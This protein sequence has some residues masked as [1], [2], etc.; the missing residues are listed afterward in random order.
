MSCS[1]CVSCEP[2]I[3][4]AFSHLG[5]IKWTW[6]FQKPAVSVNPAQSI[7]IRSSGILILPSSPRA[8]ILPA[9]ITTAPLLIGFS[10][11]EGYIFAPIRTTLPPLSRNGDLL[12]VGGMRRL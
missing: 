1:C 6:L 8:T 3:E 4:G 9:R 11:G 10:D 2:E 7:L 12:M 5:S